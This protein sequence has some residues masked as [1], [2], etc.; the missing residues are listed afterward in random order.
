MQ[1]ITFRQRQ[2]SSSRTQTRWASHKHPLRPKEMKRRRRS[3]RNTSVYIA[4]LLWTVQMGVE[5]F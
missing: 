3:F 1:A 2:Q 5:Q 4:D